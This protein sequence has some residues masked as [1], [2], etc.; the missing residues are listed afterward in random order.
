[1]IAANHPRAGTGNDTPS[2]IY[3]LVGLRSVANQVSGAN[4]LIV[5]PASVLQH[6][7]KSY[8]VGVDVAQDQV[9]HNVLA[10]MAAPLGSNPQITSRTSVAL[11]EALRALTYGTRVRIRTKEPLPC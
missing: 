8:E 2:P 10:E 9:S 3:N 5:A 4:N 7:F 6:L 1:V 11:R